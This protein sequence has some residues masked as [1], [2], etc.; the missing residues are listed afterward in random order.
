MWEKETNILLE[1]LNVTYVKKVKGYLWDIVSMMLS[2]PDLND[3]YFFFKFWLRPDNQITYPKVTL[4]EVE[5]KWKDQ[6]VLQQGKS[7]R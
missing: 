5:R 7:C 3:S 4:K 6:M 1:T 2:N